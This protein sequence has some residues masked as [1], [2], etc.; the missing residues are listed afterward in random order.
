[1]K[2]I[3]LLLIT[4]TPLLAFSQCI[5][6]NCDNGYGVYLLDGDWKGDKYQGEFKNGVFEGLG[7]Y[8]WDDGDKYVGEWRDGDLHGFGSMYFLS[9]GKNQGDVFHGEYKDGVKNGI[10]TYIWKNGKGDVS[11]YID[12][13]E[14]KRLCDFEK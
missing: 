2:K 12:D 14:I 7:T 11:Y 6:G 1:M 4:L 10:G 9:Q 3:I 5:S 8:I 13:K